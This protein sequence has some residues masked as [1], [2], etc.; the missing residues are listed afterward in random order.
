MKRATRRQRRV[1]RE[2]GRSERGEQ[3]ATGEILRFAQDDKAGVGV[4]LEVRFRRSQ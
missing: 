1:L 2:E 4:E 3:D